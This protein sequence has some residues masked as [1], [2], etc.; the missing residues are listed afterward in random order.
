M[1]IIPDPIHVALLTLP[2]LVTVAGGHFILW[3]PLMAYLEGR[4]DTIHTA[5]TEAKELEAATADHLHTLEQ[6][7]ASARQRATQLFAEARGRAQVKEAGILADARGRADA[8]VS[9]AVASIHASRQA[10]SQALT[11]SASELS[12]DIAAQVLGRDVA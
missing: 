6:R 11:Q 2:F 9:E 8:R 12:R 4:E 10:A 1:E 5:R 7:L 3:K